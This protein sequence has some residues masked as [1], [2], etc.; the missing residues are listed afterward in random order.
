MN[1]SKFTF[2]ILGIVYFGIAIGSL[3]SNSIVTNNVVLGLSITSLLISFGDTIDTLCSVFMLRNAY[4]FALDATVE[5]LNQKIQ[6]NIQPAINVDV[7]N[8]RSG[9]EGLKTSK[10]KSIKHPSIY[11]KNRLFRYASIIS[12]VLFILSIAVFILMPFFPESVYDEKASRIIT[13][14]AFAFICMSIF[15]ND[16]RQEIDSAKNR[17][18]NETQAII[19]SAYIDYI[20]AYQ[21]QM[22][23]YEAYTEQKKQMDQLYKQG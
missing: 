13:I 9:I 3:L 20:T 11:Q 19:N 2:C 15:L 7:R 10:A 8:I 4:N 5:F 1:K 17:F 22:Q 18:E 21:G 6:Y 14:F 16:W 23:H 12:T